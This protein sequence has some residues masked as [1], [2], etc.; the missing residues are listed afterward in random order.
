M[1][2]LS[3][4]GQRIGVTA[5]SPPFHQPKPVTSPGQT[6]AVG[7]VGPA[8]LVGGTGS[9]MSKGR[10]VGKGANWSDKRSRLEKSCQ[11][12]PLLSPF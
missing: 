9:H 12:C 11:S 4:P 1:P 7:Q 10:P 5:A 2:S 3:R 6:D 8:P